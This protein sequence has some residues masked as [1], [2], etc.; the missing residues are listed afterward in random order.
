MYNNEPYLEA[1]D[2]WGRIA[3]EENVSRSELAFRWM[4]YHSSLKAELGDGITIGGRLAQLEGI[5]ESVNQGPLSEQAVEK[6][7]EL[8]EKLQPHVKYL[9]NLQAMQ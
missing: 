2:E 6:I 5:F 8:W 4:C 1:Q 9:H 7:Q 3:K